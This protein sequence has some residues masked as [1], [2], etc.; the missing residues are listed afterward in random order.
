[1]TKVEL[2]EQSDAEIF[3][4]DTIKDGKAFRQFTVERAGRGGPCTLARVRDA[5][6]TVLW[7]ADLRQHGVA[8]NVTLCSVER[9]VYRG[10]LVA[11]VWF[12][13]ADS[14]RRRRAIVDTELPIVPAEG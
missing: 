9:S 2:F 6:G 7:E 8:G 11:T 12:I 13:P 10:T 4:A 14:W 3:A 5:A 1:M